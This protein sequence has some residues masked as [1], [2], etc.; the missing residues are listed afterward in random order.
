DLGARHRDR[1]GDPAIADRAVARPHHAGHRPPA[2]HHP[3]R[4]PHRRGGRDRHRGAGRPCR[5]AA[6]QGRLCE[7]AR[8]PVR[9]PCFGRNGLMTAPFYEAVVLARTYLT[10]GMLRLT[11]GG[12]G[13]RAFPVTGVPDEYLRL[14]FPHPE[15]GRLHLPHIDENGRWTYPDGQD[16]IRCSTYTVRDFRKAGDGVVEM[17][18]DFVVHEG[19]AASEWAQRVEPGAAIT[20]NRPRGLYTPPADMAWQVLVA[21]ATGLPALARILEN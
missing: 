5:P 7:A 1:A 13:L 21:D 18:I 3:A 2:R 12:E 4:R 20:I 19:G 10:P 14:F 15:T 11:F 17:D 9:R 8:R 16:K 6:A